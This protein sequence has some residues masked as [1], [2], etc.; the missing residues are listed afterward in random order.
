M[1]ARM[2]PSRSRGVEAGPSPAAV[3][4]I[5]LSRPLTC[6]IAFGGR[7]QDRAIGHGT[8][9]VTI[10][11]LAQVA[12]ALPRSREGGS[13][14]DPAGWVLMARAGPVSTGNPGVADAS[15]PIASEHRTSAGAVCIGRYPLPPAS[16]AQGLRIPTSVETQPLRCLAQATGFDSPGTMT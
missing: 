8:P 9:A 14:D 2:K 1:P 6:S 15:H 4:L 10:A 11:A 7:S 16:T 13:S 12:L 5:T 3:S